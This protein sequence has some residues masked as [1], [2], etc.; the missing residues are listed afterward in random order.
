MKALI[1]AAGYATRLYPLTKETPKPLLK[2]AGRP[3]INY[4]VDKLKDIGGIDKIFV[5][6]NAKFFS[7]F[8]N[9]A[10]QANFKNKLKII[11]DGTKSE[12]TRL[13]AIGDIN[14]AIKKKRINDD[15]L[16]LGGDNLFTGGLGGFIKKALENKPALTIGLFDINDKKAAARYGVAEIDRNKRVVS[17]KEKPSMP[18]STLAAMCLYYLP[19]EK[20]GLT[21]EYLYGNRNLHRNDATGNYISWLYKKQ[22]IY[23]FVFRGRWYDIGHVDAYKMADRVFTQAL[24]RDR[25][26]MSG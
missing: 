3:I 24:K 6:T 7:H 19:K 26:V 2:I 16:V 17:F 10:A 12:K 23:G 14:L 4:L 11:N 15:L 8:R 13:G 21:N 22:P 9:W 18:R 5:V 1:L 25:V 20:L